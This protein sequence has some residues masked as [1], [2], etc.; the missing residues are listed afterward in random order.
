MTDVGQLQRTAVFD[1]CR[2]GEDHRSLS[3]LLKDLEKRVEGDE[4]ATDAVG[5]TVARPLHVV[6]Q[7]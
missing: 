6:L 4:P 3:Q 2:D 1:L 7:A 5:S